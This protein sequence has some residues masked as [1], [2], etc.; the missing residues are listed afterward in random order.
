MKLEIRHLSRFTYRPIGYN[1]L[2]IRFLDLANAITILSL[3]CGLACALLAIRQHLAFALIALIVSGLCDLFDGFVARRLSRTK[4]QR[5]FGGRLDS[6]VDACSFGF[7]PAILLF[8]VGLTTPAELLLIF[9]LPTCAI[10]RLAYFE[11]TTPPGKPPRYHEGMPT[12]Y[13]ALFLPLG[14]LIG[15]LTPMGMRPAAIGTAIALSVAMVCRLRIPK[16]RGIAYIF[17]LLAGIASIV[18]LLILG[19]VRGQFIE[20]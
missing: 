16:P 11:T 14:L 8:A 6:L 10:W 17:F 15:Q 5:L 2:M 7:A 12:T 18:A 1:C 9:L 4:E 3:G 13:V 20:P 19:G